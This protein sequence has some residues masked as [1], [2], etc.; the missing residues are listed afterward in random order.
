M[1]TKK[2][3]YM[4]IHQMDIRVPP[5]RRLGLGEVLEGSLDFICIVYFLYTTTRNS[6]IIFSFKDFFFND[7]KGGEKK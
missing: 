4:V 5:G 7:E 2:Q 6:H 1:H 3:L